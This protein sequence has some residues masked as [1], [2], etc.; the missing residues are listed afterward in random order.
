MIFA[1]SS[2]YTG[3]ASASGNKDGFNY[4]SDNNYK[5]LL[6]CLSSDQ[7]DGDIQRFEPLGCSFDNSNGST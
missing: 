5:P 3:V 2:G 6:N 4:E 7:S 1:S